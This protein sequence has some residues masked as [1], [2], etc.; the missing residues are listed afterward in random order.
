MKSFRKSNTSF[1]Y[2]TSLGNFENLKLNLNTFINLSPYH[3]GGVDEDF[4]CY[5]VVTS[6]TFENV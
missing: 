2:N 5:I 4:Y 1:K 6:I 3:N